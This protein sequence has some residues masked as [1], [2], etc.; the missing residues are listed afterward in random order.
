MTGKRWK[1]RAAMRGTSSCISILARLFVFS[2][3]LFSG[4]D[5]VGA[6]PLRGTL[7]NGVPFVGEYVVTESRDE[8]G[9]LVHTVKRSLGLAGLRTDRRQ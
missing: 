5:R 2:A 7:A 4:A 3:L 8:D 9:V 6:E 1:G